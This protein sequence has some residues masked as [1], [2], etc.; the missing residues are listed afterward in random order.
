MSLMIVRVGLCG[1]TMSMKDYAQHFPVVEV[2]STFYE[3]ARDT[4]MPSMPC[5][6]SRT[7]NLVLP[8]RA[9]D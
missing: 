6:G 8:S 5:N 7:W 4:A 9:P 2:Q 3:P 1:F